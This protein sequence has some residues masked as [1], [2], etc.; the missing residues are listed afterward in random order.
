M[1]GVAT[2]RSCPSSRRNRGPLQIGTGVRLRRNAQLVSATGRSGASPDRTFTGGGD[3]AFR[4]H[5]VFYSRKC[6]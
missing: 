6:V 4:T 1:P 5:H 2:L 3:A